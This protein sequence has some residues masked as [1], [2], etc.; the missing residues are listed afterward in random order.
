MPSYLVL[1]LNSRP[2]LQVK[3]LLEREP[4]VSPRF[5]P[6]SMDLGALHQYLQVWGC[7]S[8]LARLECNAWFHFMHSYR[9]VR[10]NG[11]MCVTVVICA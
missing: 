4:L 1:D 5:Q 6:G 9:Y 10:D 2:L 8:N 7:A 11:D 3:A